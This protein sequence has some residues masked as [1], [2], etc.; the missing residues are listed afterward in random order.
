MPFLPSPYPTTAAQINFPGVGAALAVTIS[1][2]GGKPPYTAT[3]ASGICGGFGNP[4]VSIA[5]VPGQSS[6]FNIIPT[7]AGAGT[8]PVTFADS[9]TPSPQTTVLTVYVNAGGTGAIT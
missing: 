3:A 8:C 1:V 7:L 4:G 2:S 5:Q 6:Q 9:T